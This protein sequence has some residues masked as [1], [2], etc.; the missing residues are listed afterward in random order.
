MA[1]I[2]SLVV[3]LGA[4]VFV[5]KLPT[6]YAIDMQLLGGVWITQLFPAVILGAFTRRCHPWALLVGWAAGMGS[7]TAMV[8]STGMKPVYALHCCGHVWPMYAAVP[9]VTLNL[10]I[11]VALT[12]LLKAARV[13]PGLDTTVAEDYA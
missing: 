11:T 10:A 1:K 12:L 4:L 13:S 9:A 8:I 7:G 5:L 2:V 6:A 3:K